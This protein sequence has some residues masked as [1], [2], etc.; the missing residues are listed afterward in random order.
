MNNKRTLVNLYKDVVLVTHV[1][2]FC[3]VLLT[4]N[5]IKVVIQ[6]NAFLAYHWTAL[7]CFQ[8]LP[9]HSCLNFFKKN[10]LKIL[11]C[12]SPC[13]FFRLI[14]YFCA[15]STEESS[16]LATTAAVNDD[17]RFNENIIICTNEIFIIYTV[18]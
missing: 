11:K 2:I 8:S 9:K 6:I 15:K 5:N 10:I 18:K 7:I 1:R 12:Y 17:S 14:N 13:F 4:N 3:T 16:S